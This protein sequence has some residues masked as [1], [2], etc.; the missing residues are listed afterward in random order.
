MDNVMP[1]KLLVWNVQKVSYNNNHTSHFD[2]ALNFYD[3]PQ[4]FCHSPE[5]FWE[6]FQHSIV[7]T[8]RQDLNQELASY[9]YHCLLFFFKKFSF[10][11]IWIA[12]TLLQSVLTSAWSQKKS[13][14][15]KKT[16]FGISL[17]LSNLF[18]AKKHSP[19]G[20]LIIFLFQI[21]FFI[22]N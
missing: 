9:S 11:P 19:C 10:S 17:P 22:F 5:L 20:I 16:K 2:A 6:R 21:S 3:K 1:L 4:N 7:S 18:L 14:L 13:L 8:L 12:Q 15:A